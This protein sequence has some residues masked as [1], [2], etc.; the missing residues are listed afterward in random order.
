[1]ANKHGVCEEFVA[2]VE[3]LGKAEGKRNLLRL[4]LLK[5]AAKYL[6]K[7]A[8]WGDD[9]YHYNYAAEAKGMLDAARAYEAA[10]NAVEET[11]G[12]V[13]ENRTVRFSDPCTNV[14]G[15]E[16]SYPGWTLPKDDRG[17][18]YL[19]NHIGSIAEGQP[20]SRCPYL[21]YGCLACQETLDAYVRRHGKA[22]ARTEELPVQPATQ[23]LDKPVE[24]PAVGIAAADLED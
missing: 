19:I 4:D 7:E 17:F 18:E 15:P 6:L 22:V 20:N 3:A 24:G 16:F 1:M 23:E 8:T 9:K 13:W 10:L 21:S 14:G 2:R 12:R 11:G 5:A